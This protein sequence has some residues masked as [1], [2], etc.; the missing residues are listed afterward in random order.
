MPTKLPPWGLIIHL[1]LC[2]SQLYIPVYGPHSASYTRGKKRAA[3]PVSSN[4]LRLFVSQN[5]YYFL[6]ITNTA[7]N[8]TCGLAK[9]LHSCGTTSCFNSLTIKV[10]M[11]FT[12]LDSRVSW[13]PGDCWFIACLAPPEIARGVGNSWHKYHYIQCLSS[14]RL[15]HTPWPTSQT[16]HKIASGHQPEFNATRPRAL[17]GFLVREKDHPSSSQ[18]GHKE[19]PAMWH[20]DFETNISAKMQVCFYF[21]GKLYEY[22]FFCIVILLF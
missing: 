11:S 15:T 20:Q 4:L 13:S 5:I 14:S 10:S 12:F 8:T 18:T 21:T 1:I 2:P 6:N 3:Y 16:E 22:P 17:H 19:D 9:T 7:H